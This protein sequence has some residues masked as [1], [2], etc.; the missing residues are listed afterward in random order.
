MRRIS[1]GGYPAKQCAR[2]THNR[3]SPSAPLPAPV[4]AELQMLFD[5]GIVFETAVVD[6]LARR[7][8]NLL[9]INEDDWDLCKQLTVTALEAGIPLVAGGRLPDV[10]GRVGAPDLLVRHGCGY[11]PVDIKNHRTLS[12]TTNPQS[13]RYR[14]RVTISALIAPDT[15]VSAAGYSNKAGHWRDDT[16]QL[17][18]YTRMLQELGFHPGAD[19]LIGGIIGNSDLTTL[20]GDE[21]GVIWYDLEDA[22]EPTF[23][24]SEPSHRK[25]RSPLERYDHEFGFRITVAQAALDGGEIVRPFRTRDCDT[26]EWFKYC[27][28][29]VSAD[30]AS[31]ALAAGHLNVREW[32]YLYGDGQLSVGQLAEIDSAACIDGFRKHSVGTQNP[33]K[34]LNDAIHRAQMTVAGIEFE[35]RGQ[36]P[37]VPVADV[38][39]D[40]DIE[41]DT[42]GRI[43]QWGLRIRDGQDDATARYEPV[44]SF[45]VLDEAAEEALADAV[46]LRLNSLNEQARQEGKSLTVFHWHHVEVSMTRKFD[47]VATALDGVTV[48]LL[49]WFNRHFFARQ[50]ASIKN[51]A[52]LFGFAWGVD[53]PGGRISQDKIAVAR[54]GGPEA[55][56]AREWCLR[57]N[58]SDVAAQAAIRDGL[59]S[60]R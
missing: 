11:L 16:M 55:G 30:D 28:E 40:F 39:V 56:A 5:G 17:A 4:S 51:I 18:H 19:L 14:A 41:W 10:N 1:L 34:R 54:G 26:C 22:A 36:W 33:Q 50:S 58:E 32:L 59:R 38:E 15:R 24:A 60:L 48:D 13:P 45:E 35:P 53:D 44:V 21:L 47:E 20:L 3:Y 57:Y 25:R 37:E 27:S 46:G 43:Y 2:I 12:A 29:V 9:V 6:E 8:P 31:F 52:P 23:S 7:H 49:D 42:D